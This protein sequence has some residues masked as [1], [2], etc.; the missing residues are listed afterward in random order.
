MDPVPCISRK[1][2]LPDQDGFEQGRLTRTGCSRIGDRVEH[3]D[4]LGFL[5]TRRDAG[6]G[7]GGI[8]L[9]QG[10]RTEKAYLHSRQSIAVQ[11]VKN[12]IINNDITV[13]R[14]L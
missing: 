11:I 2:G 5:E 7:T 6:V 13:V 4:D 9:C 14:R 1:G 12:A 8:H 10:K 3:A